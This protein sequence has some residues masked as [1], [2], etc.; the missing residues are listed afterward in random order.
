MLR[1]LAVILTLI[2]YT[3]FSFGQSK[4]A[5]VKDNSF[6][7]NKADVEAL[8]E[9]SDYKNISNGYEISANVFTLRRIRIP[10]CAKDAACVAYWKKV[11]QDLLKDKKEAQQIIYNKVV[12]QLS[13]RYSAAQVKWLLQIY[14]TPLF[15]DF[16]N[17]YKSENGPLPFAD[18]GLMVEEKTKNIKPYTDSASPPLAEPPSEQSSSIH[19]EKQNSQS[20]SNSLYFPPIPDFSVKK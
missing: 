14:K 1:L 18:G 5:S 20:P 6:H 17:F 16:L 4:P 7:S 2:H 9:A 13:K 3:N 12:D 15:Q 19:Q 8:I 10:K 11:E